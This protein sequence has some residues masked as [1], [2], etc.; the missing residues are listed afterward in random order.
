MLYARP[1]LK[2]RKEDASVAGGVVGC[3]DEELEEVE[4][5]EEEEEGREAP[6]R[7]W[8]GEAAGEGGGALVPGAGGSL[9]G[10]GEG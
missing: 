3:G 10:A 4:G 9:L 8:D 5:G 2:S 7:G 6:E 1:L